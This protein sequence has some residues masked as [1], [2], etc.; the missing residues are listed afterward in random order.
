MEILRQGSNERDSSSSLERSGPVMLS[1]AKHLVAG[2]PD[3]SL[4][5]G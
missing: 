3:P 1:A 4:R 5:S 2:P